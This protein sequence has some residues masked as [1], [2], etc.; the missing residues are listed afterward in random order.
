MSKKEEKTKKNVYERKFS[1]ILGNFFFY[2]ITLI[3]AFYLSNVFLIWVT[4]R[5]IIIYSLIIILLDIFVY[6]S[7]KDS[8]L[9][10]V[11]GKLS[12]TEETYYQ[13]EIQRYSKKTSLFRILP[14][15]FGVAMSVCI[16]IFLMLLVPLVDYFLTMYVSDWKSIFSSIKWDFI[17]LFQFL[18]LIFC[19]IIFR[20]SHYE[21]KFYQENYENIENWNQRIVV[22]N[23]ISIVSIFWKS[24]PLFQLEC[25][26]LWS[27]KTKKYYL[28]SVTPPAQVEPG[29]PLYLYEDPSDSRRYLI[30]L[31]SY[32]Q[33]KSKSEHELLLEEFNNNSQIKKVGFRKKFSTFFFEKHTFLWCLILVI[34][35]PV[36]LIVVAGIWKLFSWLLG[37][38]GESLF[39]ILISIGIIFLIIKKIV[40]KA[41]KKYV[42]IGRKE[43]FTIKATIISF[44]ESGYIAVKVHHPETKKALLLSLYYPFQP[45]E[46]K[47]GGHIHVIME[48]KDQSRYE[49]VPN[50]YQEPQGE[51]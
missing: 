8:I 48:K 35:L 50:S 21:R 3:S 45:G 36:F 37:R 2:L 42:R 1:N 32:N 38:F 15:D 9:E 41:F 4:T 26:A 25:V 33:L 47:I 34:I 10:L 30:D 24:L 22:V 5:G 13:Q 27:N 39:W 46:W 16:L 43:F 29:D 17:S 19:Y 11:G 14:R 28:L 44:S 31:R 23:T 20:S 18:F 51:I 12:K 40:K 49:S 7:V 6:K